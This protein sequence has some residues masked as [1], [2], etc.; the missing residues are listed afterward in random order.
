[1]DYNLPGSSVHRILQERILEW[2]AMP[3]SRGCF[4]RR[5]QTSGLLHLLHWQAGCLPLAP[6]GK[7]HISGLLMIIMNFFKTDFF[8]G[9]IMLKKWLLWYTVYEN[10]EI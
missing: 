2:D 6:P 9:S 4:Q 1:M 8:F 3:Y 10:Q 7:P 5:G